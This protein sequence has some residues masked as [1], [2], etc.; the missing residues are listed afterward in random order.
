MTE[1]C[2]M[3][4]AASIVRKIYIK[5]YKGMCHSHIPFFNLWVA[6]GWSDR[7]KGVVVPWPVGR[8]NLCNMF[9]SRTDINSIFVPI[10]TILSQNDITEV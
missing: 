5:N 3:I 7:G 8:H 10:L 6:A 1:A 4:T 9:L 2:C